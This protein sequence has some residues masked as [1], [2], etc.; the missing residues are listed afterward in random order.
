MDL[1]NIRTTKLDNEPQPLQGFG[2]LRSVRFEAGQKQRP[3]H[4]A[5]P[6]IGAADGCRKSGAGMEKLSVGW[7][8]D[9]LFFAEAAAKLSHRRRKR[10][11]TGQSGV[12]H[13]L[14]RFVFGQERWHR[15][16]HL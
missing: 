5:E 2:V 14:S 6:K 4:P 15:W 1:G 12:L 13:H 16:P 8:A 7:G 10:R 11:H 3:R 9:R